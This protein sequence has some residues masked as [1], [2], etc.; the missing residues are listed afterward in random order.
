M[1][2]I[3]VASKMSKIRFKVDARIVR[4]IYFF[5]VATKTIGVFLLTSRISLCTIVIVQKM[6]S[7]SGAVVYL[8]L[9][10]S[11]LSNKVTISCGVLLVDPVQY[12]VD[13][14]ATHLRK[15]C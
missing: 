11:S 1:L 14:I 10:K 5:C 9:L 13:P 12:S 4:N 2:P 8:N 15:R 6:I 3:V 7:K